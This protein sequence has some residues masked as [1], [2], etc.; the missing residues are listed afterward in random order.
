M[1]ERQKPFI[2]PGEVVSDEDIDAMD[3]P[4]TPEE[5][6]DYEDELRAI[7]K[8]EREAAGDYGIILG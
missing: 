5:I 4:A 1:S 7:D 6:A 3:P 8:A 2:I